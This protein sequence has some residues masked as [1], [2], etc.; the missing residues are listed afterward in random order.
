MSFLGWVF[1]VLA[2]LGVA[3]LIA[4]VSGLSASAPRPSAP[5]PTSTP[6]KH[7]ATPAP[8]TE[9][10]VSS[11]VTVGM[12]EQEV[13]SLLGPPHRQTNTDEYFQ[14]MKNEGVKVVVGGDKRPQQS[15]WLYLNQPPGYDTQITLQEDRVVNARQVP[16]HDKPAASRPDLDED[17]ERPGVQNIVDAAQGLPVASDAEID[18]DFSAVVDTWG[19]VEV[20]KLTADDLR[21]TVIE[22]LCGDVR[23]GFILGKINVREGFEGRAGVFLQFST[24]RY[25]G[26]QPYCIAKRQDGT[27]ALYG[28]R[29]MY[30]YRD[31]Y[32]RS[33]HYVASLDPLVQELL[34]VGVGGGYLIRDNAGRVHVS[35]RAREIGTHLDRSGGISVM[36]AVHSIVS[37]KLG[38][39][40][41]RQLDIAW[42]GIGRWQS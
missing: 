34:V 4:K 22:T 6:R 7:S 30:R 26:F 10:G 20:L 38:R 11:A 39:A 23:E 18:A 33:H 21:W 14:K 41:D 16:T 15:F 8:V 25:P 2:L 12:S 28:H 37:D 31:T 5:Q 36:R 9:A 42:D 29:A 40:A 27:F 35:P 24:L 13:R 17:V 1:A 19:A 3:L 32:L